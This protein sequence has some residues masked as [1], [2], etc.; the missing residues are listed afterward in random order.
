MSR[1][2]DKTPV[3]PIPKVLVLSFSQI[4]RDP[5]VLRQIRLYNQFAEVISCGH[6]PA[7]NGVA[8]HIQVPDSFPAW[9]AN[10]FMAAAYLGLRRHEQLYFGSDRIKFVQEQIPPGSVDVIVAND[11]LAVPLA[12]SLRPRKGIH[13][14]L[15]EYAPK[16]MENDR[17]WR[18]TIG[19][20]MDW[21][22][23]RYVTQV[24]SVS[25]VAEGIAKEYAAVYGIR[26]PAVVPN[27][28]VFNSSAVP[29]PV[30]APLRLVHTGAAGR[31]RKIEVMV[32]A[33]E[34]AN[35]IR[36]GTATLDL[37]LVPGDRRYIEE[38]S[39]M[40]TAVPN[41]TVRMRP[42]VP[43]NEIVP[44]LQDY[45]VGVFI[46][47][48]STFNLKHALPNKLFEFV[49]ARLA[50]LIGPSPEMETIVN[51]YGLGVVSSGFDAASVAESILALDQSG[52]A[53]MKEASHA[54]ARALSAECLTGPWADAVRLLTET[55]HV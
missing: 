21:A 48:P 1:T 54:S 39:A 41:E 51:K 11:A 42:P 30:A 14:D 40:A 45:D 19:P 15:H 12:V 37:V 16:Q 20:L 24:G 23:R 36:P 47:P 26:E 55:K 38:I 33:V 31:G 29:T 10:K 53:R 52:V 49:Q 35:R 32:K 5:R 34:I 3:L 8:R 2:P 27:A 43:F 18:L 28:A 25:T 46:C 13:A 9:R 17:K 44:M 22:C 6:G 4:V 7:P 50:V